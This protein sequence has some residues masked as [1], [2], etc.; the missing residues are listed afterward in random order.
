M[1]KVDLSIIIV[2][3]NTKDFLRQCL[4]GLE[5]ESRRVKELEI[6]V[7]DNGSTDGS[8]GMVEK[9][10]PWV[11]LIENKVNLG[12][13]AANNLGIKNSSG[14][15]VLLLN[16]DTIVPPGTLRTMVDFMDKHPEVGAATCRIELPDGS[17]D[18]ACHRG[19]PT[20]W[21]ALAY[22]TSLAKIFPKSKLFASYSL[23]YLPLDKI[24]EIDS[25]CG[26]FLIIRREPGDQIGWLDEDYFWY[27]ED[28]DF[29]YRLKQ[30]GWKI[31][32]VPTTKIIHY[33]GVASGI[34]KH[35]QKMST[36]NKETRIRAAKA[37]TEVMRIFFRKHY[38]KKYS[39]LLYW[40]VM[41]GIDFLEKVRL[42]KVS[43]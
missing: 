11:R 3:Y 12:F 16:P 42:L 1:E 31:M 10:F 13:A 8:P 41:K 14:R 39:K 27:G 29:C 35:T 26:A 15:Y 38:R 4:E 34:K 30:K 5:Q 23:T 2:N 37:S 17:L 18:Q 24:H 21:N 19:F 25:G 28:L 9:E 33:K 32:F 36:A 6:I 40:L 7:V 20:P 22:F 43:L